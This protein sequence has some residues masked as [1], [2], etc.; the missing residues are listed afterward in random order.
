MPKSLLLAIMLGAAVI[1]TAPQ[2]LPAPTSF[3]D[4]PVRVQV[5]R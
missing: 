4:V 5:L 2:W 1:V 3:V